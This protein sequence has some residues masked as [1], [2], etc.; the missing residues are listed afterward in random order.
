MSHKLHHG[1]NRSHGNTRSRTWAP[2]HTRAPGHA[3]WPRSRRSYSYVQYTDTFKSDW[4]SDYWFCVICSLFNV[5]VNSQDAYEYE[6][7]D[8]GHRAW[9]GALVWPVAHVCD[10]VCRVTC[11]CRGVDYETYEI[12]LRYLVTCWSK[13][14]WNWDT[15]TWIW[16]KIH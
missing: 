9:P 11:Y 5:E 15:E 16:S 4:Y 13:I 10:L 2:G 6:R 12:Q 8:L 1:S 7:R 14:N 3:R